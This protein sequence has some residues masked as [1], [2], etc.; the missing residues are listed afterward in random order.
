MINNDILNI[1]EYIK[2]ITPNNNSLIGNAN[3]SLSLI[4]NNHNIMDPSLLISKAAQLLN[5][6]NPQER[7]ELEGQFTEVISNPD[8]LEFC[9][10]LLN[11]SP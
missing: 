11:Q 7:T 1:P 3:Q 8:N 2:I 4:I 10:K 6:S 9:L 5:S